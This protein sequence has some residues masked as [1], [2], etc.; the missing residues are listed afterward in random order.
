MIVESGLK[1]HL[2]LRRRVQADD[3]LTGSAYYMQVTEEKQ[4]LQY[5]IL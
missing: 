5:V 1:N 2:K 4:F 3:T